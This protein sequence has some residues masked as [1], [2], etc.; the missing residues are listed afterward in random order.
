MQRVLRKLLWGGGWICLAHGEVQWR[1]FV[2][3]VMKFMV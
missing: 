1:G 3:T 2:S